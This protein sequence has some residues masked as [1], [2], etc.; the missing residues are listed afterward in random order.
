[1]IDMEKIKY[2]GYAFAYSIKCTKC[3][4]KIKLLYG[5]LPPKD[6]LA[7]LEAKQGTAILMGCIVPLGVEKELELMEKTFV[8]KKCKNP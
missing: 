1:V 3:K 8:C 7:L 5:E 6:H 4:N 2:S